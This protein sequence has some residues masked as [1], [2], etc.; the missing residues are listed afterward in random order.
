MKKYYFVGLAIIL[1]VALSLIFYGAYLNESGENQ[2]S[3][4][5]EERTIPLQGEKV[6][7][8]NLQPI[9]VLNAINLSSESMADAVALI[10]GRIE[11]IFVEKNSKVRRGQ[12]IFDLVNEDIPIKIKQAESSIAKA[13]ARDTQD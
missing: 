4:R 9:F 7:F 10:D 5:M 13:E 1:L 8:R 3:K 2:I 11:N 6:Q 12:I